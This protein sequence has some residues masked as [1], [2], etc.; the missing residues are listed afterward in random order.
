MQNSIFYNKTVKIYREHLISTVR[1]RQ[2]MVLTS[3]TEPNGFL[4]YVA[5]TN[6]V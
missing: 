4:N 1:S 5:V 2:S 3:F 6:T